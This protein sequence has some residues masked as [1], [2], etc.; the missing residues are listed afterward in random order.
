MSA[1]IATIG[2]PGA[3]GC[4]HSQKWPRATAAPCW[5]SLLG[6][7]ARWGAPPVVAEGGFG[8]GVRWKGCRRG[9]REIKARSVHT[10]RPSSK[11][12][13]LGMVSSAACRPAVEADGRDFCNRRRIGAPSL[14]T[15]HHR[16]QSRRGPATGQLPCS[17]GSAPFRCWMS[18]HREAAALTATLCKEASFAACAVQ[19]KACC[20][21]DQRSYKQNAAATNEAQRLCAA[22]EVGS[23]RLRLRDEVNHSF[24]A[25]EAH[26]RGCRWPWRDLVVR[27][28]CIWL[29]L[30]AGLLPEQHTFNKRAV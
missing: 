10:L 12:L 8:L 16:Q 6:P 5:Q 24:N 26:R 23:A 11:N 19:R 29:V 21:G 7:R 13:A 3:A 27:M 9:G 14:S 15:S 4:C 25:I 30:Y 22:E 2:R 18:E 28:V 17:S 20:G 1:G